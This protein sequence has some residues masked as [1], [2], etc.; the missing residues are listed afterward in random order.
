[1][2]WVIE[3]QYQLFAC[4]LLTV[5]GIF[6]TP[7][8]AQNPRSSAA[9]AGANNSIV[10]F[11]RNAQGHARFNADGTGDMNGDTGRYEI[12]GNQIT[13]MGQQGQVTLLFEVR[14]D[15]LTLTLNGA[16]ITMNRVR[17]E[18]GPGGIR[19]EL[20]GKWCWVSVVNA[21]Q[22]ARTSNRCSRSM[23][24]APT[25]ITAR[26]TATTHTVA[27]LRKAPT[28]APG[29]RPKPPSPPIRARGAR[30]FTRW[31]NATIR[32]TTIRC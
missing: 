7:G 15:I 23:P 3:N 17:E 25:S 6:T 9:H 28:Q 4:C 29:Q 1:M 19:P 8:Y 13:L 31:K 26:S 24:T 14:D 12:H 22:G 20:V 27:R 30:W 10:G 16:S 21:Q 32:R 2:R 5:L 18:A 11:W